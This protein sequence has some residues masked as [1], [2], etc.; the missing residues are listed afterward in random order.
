MGLVI[1]LLI[2]YDTLTIFGKL[3]GSDSVKG[4]SIFEK[5]LSGS[6]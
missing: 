1:A 5:V 4:D 2:S 3:L 6:K